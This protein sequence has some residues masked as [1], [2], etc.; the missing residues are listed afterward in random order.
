MVTKNEN[1]SDYLLL[2][3][4]NSYIIQID[5][6]DDKGNKNKVLTITHVTDF[7]EKISIEKEI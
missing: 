1:V 3:H 5:K 2:L 4:D 7:V 6:D